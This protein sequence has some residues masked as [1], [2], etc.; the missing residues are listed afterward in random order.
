MNLVQI[1]LSKIEL[2]EISLVEA[3][4]QLSLFL[5]GELVYAVSCIKMFVLLELFK[6]VCPSYERLPLQH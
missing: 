3:K 5:H 4:E 2:K 6:L 1:M